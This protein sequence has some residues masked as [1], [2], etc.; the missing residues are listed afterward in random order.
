[1]INN[2]TRN[3]NDASKILKNEHHKLVNIRNYFYWLNMKGEEIQNIQIP[4]FKL[5]H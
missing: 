1:M 2:G 3:N 5:L 4:D